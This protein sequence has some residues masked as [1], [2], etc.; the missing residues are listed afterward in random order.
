MSITRREFIKA[1]AA[2]TKPKDT[3]NKN[4]FIKALAA[5]ASN[6]AGGSGGDGGG[7]AGR[8]STSRG[9]ESIGSGISDIITTYKSKNK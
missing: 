6:R 1:A 4:E 8:S 5:T 3:E 2:S 9:I 7:D